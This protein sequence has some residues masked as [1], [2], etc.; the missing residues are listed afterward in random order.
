MKGFFAWVALAA[1]SA[2][3]L[4]NGVGRIPVMGWTSWEPGAREPSVQQC[5]QCCN[6]WVACMA[7][8]HN[9]CIN[10]V[11]GRCRPAESQVVWPEHNRAVCEC[12]LR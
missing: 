12:S 7:C 1:S 6:A 8:M 9:P 3:A 2:H 11:Q 4:D 5:K 10:S